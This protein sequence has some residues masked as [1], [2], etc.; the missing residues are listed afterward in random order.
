MVLRASQSGTGTR[1]TMKFANEAGSGKQSV[2]GRPVL[3]RRELPGGTGP[4]GIVGQEGEQPPSGYFLLTGNAEGR[5]APLVEAARASGL[6]FSEHTTALM[7]A[8]RL[9]AFGSG[10]G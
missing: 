10:K 3:F 8:C 1:A 9:A 2:P 4:V 5:P 6:A 7:A